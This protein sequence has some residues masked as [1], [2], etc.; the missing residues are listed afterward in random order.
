MFLLGVF[1]VVLAALDVIQGAAINEKIEPVDL[2]YDCVHVQTED[3]K[4]DKIPVLLIHGLTASYRSWDGVFQVLAHLTKRKV[5]AVDLRNHGDSPWN[6][7]SDVAALA[8]DIGHFLDQQNI[9]KVNIIGHSLGGKTAVHYTLNNPDRVNS[10]VV[11]D[12]RP[13]SLTEASRSLIQNLIQILQAALKA[14]PE[15]ANEDEA[16]QSIGDYINE[17]M[18]KTGSQ[19]LFDEKTIRKLELRLVDGKWQLKW[20]V[21]VLSECLKNIETFL[22]KSSGLYEGPALFIYGT[23]SPFAVIDDKENILKLFPNAKLEPIEGASHVIHGR[24]HEF[25]DLLLKFLNKVN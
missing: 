10:I 21:D 17:K 25:D 16:K 14:I 2:K 7:R 12:M 5:C 6:N 9:K 23:K 1:L 20:N 15:G 3:K 13:N 18:K 4:H 22:T 11:E 24:Y 19:G 8:V